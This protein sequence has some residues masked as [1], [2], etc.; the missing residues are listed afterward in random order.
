M[1]DIKENILRLLHDV[2]INID[3]E[4]ELLGYFTSPASKQYHLSIDG[5]LALHSYNVYLVLNDLNNK[6]QLG[7]DKRFIVVSSLLHDIAKCDGYKKNILK[8]GEVSDKVPYVYEDT[9]PIG[10]GE[11]SVIM[12]LKMGI[13][14]T[15]DEMMAIRY[16]MGGYTYFDSGQWN[17][18]RALIAKTDYE[19][20]VLTLHCADMIASQIIELDQV[21]PE[22]SKS[23]Y[24]SSA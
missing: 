11:K 7:L 20:P 12:L 6:Y 13:D 18:A 16:H 19:V 8:S 17:M 15:N 2:G 9:F 3:K 14:L 10:H 21:Y 5:G 22:L 24:S 1:V 4:L 23:L